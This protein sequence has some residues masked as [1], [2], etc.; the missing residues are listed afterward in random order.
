MRAHERR[1]AE[2]SR[3][4]DAVRATAAP[5]Q[6]RDP[7]PAA[8]LA[9]L[10]G[11]LGNSEVAKLVER[12]R[13]GGNPVDAGHPVQR[14][15]LP[16]FQAEL[17]QHGLAGDSDFIT[18]FE[19]RRTSGDIDDKKNPAD[20][21][22]VVQDATPGSQER[23]RR[24][25]E[26]PHVTSEFVR[27]EI[28]E[29]QSGEA[30]GE[31]GSRKQ[32]KGLDNPRVVGLEIELG[33]VNLDVPEGES[34]KNT[35]LL[36]S[37]AEQT[38]VGRPVLQL[39]VEGMGRSGDVPSV[40]LIY[41]PLTSAEYGS[42]AL[43]TARENLRKALGT[44]G[45]LKERILSY[46][47]TLRTAAEKRYKLTPATRSAKLRT[48]SHVTPNSNQQ[49]N[50]STPYGKLGWR[51]EK[52]DDKDFEKFFNR[53][54]QV[55]AVRYRKAREGGAA[56]AAE[57]AERWRARTQGPEVRWPNLRSLLTQ[58]L[59]QEVQY[60]YYDVTRGAESP[61]DKH[62]FHVML[63]ASPQDVVMSILSDDEAKALLAWLVEGNERELAKEVRR[64]YN[65]APRPAADMT[66]D[67]DKLDSYGKEVAG[68]M[69][70]VLVTRLLAGQQLLETVS[71]DARRS[72]VFG[73]NRE[74]GQVEHFHPRASNRIPI[75]VQ[76]SR[77][78]MVVEQRDAGHTLNRGGPKH[79][80][81]KTV[82]DLQR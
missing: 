40:E 1:D 48:S 44:K 77:Y 47:K 69:R 64:S 45:N 62:R 50:V 76:G 11:V 60:K 61:D 3:K 29:Y 7:L 80:W 54:E 51:P 9:R 67:E 55:D 39:E 73:E 23:L 38:E 41:G 26:K 15:A 31:K 17:Q 16:E 78:Y 34:V 22:A 4:S 5:A 36:A 13:G 32:P 27:A 74:V 65:V 6:V 37:T 46:N 59:F 30:D 72:R 79:E 52:A 12:G 8:E 56:L 71:G 81:K 82:D 42:A 25:V 75:T 66:D 53:P 18:F 49:T 28:A 43:L 70:S 35:D 58:V 10:Q 68:Y 57:V 21:G 33:N 14:M 20:P 63:K 19:I 24:L 2:T